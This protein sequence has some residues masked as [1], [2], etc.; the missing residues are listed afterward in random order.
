MGDTAVPWLDDEEMRAWVGLIRLSGRLVALADG[1]LRRAHGI[2]GR[3]YELLHHLSG[4]PDGARVSELADLIDDTSSCITHRVNR[5]VTDGLVRKVADPTD[6]RAR[7]VRL[8]PAGG[9]L[10][11]RAAPEHVRRVRRWVID[12]LDR[13]QLRQLADLTEQLDDHLRLTEPV[14]RG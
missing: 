11:E 9:R 3:D 7:L 13:P 1:E 10:L 14:G 12:P 5:L 2:T 8:T 6:A 4:C